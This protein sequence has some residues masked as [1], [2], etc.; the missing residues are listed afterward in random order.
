LPALKNHPRQASRLKVK[1]I[2]TDSI[3]LIKMNGLEHREGL[4]AQPGK[5]S[6]K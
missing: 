5:I 6:R 4:S 2:A 3:P 1:L